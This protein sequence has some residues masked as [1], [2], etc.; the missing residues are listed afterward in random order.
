MLF[1][2]LRR[3]WRPGRLEVGGAFHGEWRRRLLCSAG[4][5]NLPFRRMI[6][7]DASP[8]RVAGDLTVAAREAAAFENSLHA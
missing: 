7:Q 6:R 8:T 3:L 2:G 5:M 1:Q 4:C